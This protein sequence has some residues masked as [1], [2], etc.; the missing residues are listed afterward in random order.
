MDE[1]KIVIRDM[2]DSKSVGGEIPIEILMESEFTFEI[3]T[4]YVNKSIETGCFPNSLKEANITSI[5]KKDD[6]LDKSNYRPVRIL[7]LISKVYERLIYNQLLEYTEKN[8]S[9]ISCGFRKA[10]STQC[11]LFKL[12]QSWQ[13]EL[14]NGCFVGTVLMELSK[15]Y[16]RIPHELLVAK[17]KSYGIVRL[18]FDYLTNRKQRTKICSSFSS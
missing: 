7:P 5:F 8:L 9:H 14:D 2:G 6:P 1:V 12:L 13:K 16:D 15:A 18:L 4:N 17:L 10:H 3:L 11:A